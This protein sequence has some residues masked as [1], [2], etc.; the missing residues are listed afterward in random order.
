MRSF[1]LIYVLLDI[2]ELKINSFLIDFDD[3][4]LQK[5]KLLLELFC[6]YILM[7]YDSI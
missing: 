1:N 6:I 3:L 5:K 4:R 2:P 7:K